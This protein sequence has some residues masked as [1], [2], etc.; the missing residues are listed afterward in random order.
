[1]PKQVAL[2]FA[3][4]IGCEQK[5]KSKAENKR[6]DQE[7]YRRIG[8][9]GGKAGGVARHAELTKER[10]QALGRLGGLAKARKRGLDLTS[11]GR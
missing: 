9:L 8:A 11:E 2:W 5:E 7:H 1:M 3:P 6:R 4:V 10:R